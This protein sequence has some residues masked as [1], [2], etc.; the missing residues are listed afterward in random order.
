[1]ALSSVSRFAANCFAV[2]CGCLV[3][4]MGWAVG[5]ESVDWRTEGLVTGVKNQGQCESSWAFAAIGAVEGAYAKSSGNL[6]NFSEQ[7]LIDCDTARNQGCNGGTPS[8]AL[9]YIQQQEWV[10]LEVAYP[11]SGTK[12]TCQRVAKS[13]F[14]L[15]KKVV[16]VS[17]AN[18]RALQKVVSVIGPVAARIDASHESFL[19]YKNGI[20]NEPRCS[21]TRLNWDVLVVGYGTENGQDYWLVK[22]SFGT[23][24]GERGYIKIARNRNNM[25][26]IAT[27][28]SYPAM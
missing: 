6:V 22:N 17:P 27:Q 20:Y 21:R 23:D 12:G 1:M 28:A 18:E 15:I 25:C 8:A 13:N 11:Y 5:P 3:A 26:G 24:W 19:N 7:Q 10:A 16:A 14:P 2:V 9:E 4:T